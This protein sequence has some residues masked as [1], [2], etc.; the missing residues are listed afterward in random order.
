MGQN[1]STINIMKEVLFSDSNEKLEYSFVFHITKI[2]DI[3]NENYLQLEI[4]FDSNKC[5]QFI[6]KKQEINNAIKS[7]EV[8][9]KDIKLK[10]IKNENFLEIKD[11][12][13][14]TEKLKIPEKELL[15]FYFELPDVV[16]NISTFKENNNISI[17]LKTEEIESISSF[18]YKLKDFHSQN[19]PLDLPQEYKNILEN[20]KIY[21]FNG[22]Y[23]CNYTLKPINI[24]SIEIIDKDSDI[25]KIIF[26]QDIQTIKN[27]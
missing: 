21:L 23:Y 14:T 4:S 20:D 6:I 16:Q 9:L 22:F 17:K 27:E 15:P 3:K 2:I 12:K 13:V 1:N 26:S 25:E 18:E 11:Y 7:I 8:K 19:I 5:N 24:S 10:M